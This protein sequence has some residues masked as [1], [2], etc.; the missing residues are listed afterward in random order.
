MKF[1]YFALFLLLICAGCQKEIEPPIIEPGSYYPVYPNSWWK[2]LINDSIVQRDTTSDDYIVHSYLIYDD[3]EK[4]SDPARVP[5]INGLPIYGYNFVE[6]IGYPDNYYGLNKLWPILSEKIG[7]SFWSFWVDH[8][9]SRPCELVTV[10][11][12]TFNGTDSLLLL[13]SGYT[14]INIYDHYIYPEIR[15]RT[16]VKGVGCISDIVVD[17]VTSDTLSRKILID[18]Y[19]NHQF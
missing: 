9:Y 1:I 19:V 3:P 13:V 16:F 17:T 4:Y 15:Y 12:T 8:R 5:F 11:S 18:Y 14:T 2:Y 10:Q 7:D 6:S